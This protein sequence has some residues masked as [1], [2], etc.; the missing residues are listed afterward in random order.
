MTLLKPQI[1]KKKYNLLYKKKEQLN[2]ID[3]SLKGFSWILT[4]MILKYNFP[5]TVEG[6]THLMSEFPGD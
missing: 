6:G 4:I 1:N 2:I 3:I 5:W